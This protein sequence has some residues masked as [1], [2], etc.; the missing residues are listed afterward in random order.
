MVEVMKIMA[1]SFKKSPA[2]TAA[3][4]VPE[5]ASSHCQSM[6]LPETPGHSLLGKSGSVSCGI[7]PPFF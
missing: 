4:S 6:P 5:P 1:T 2:H 3:L 7:T